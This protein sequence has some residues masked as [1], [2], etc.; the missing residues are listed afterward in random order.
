MRYFL[1]R[2]F[3]LDFF[4]AADFFAGLRVGFRATGFALALAFCFV[5]GPGIGFAFAL[6]LGF[7]FGCAAGAVSIPRN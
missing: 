2:A 6:A 3:G 5:L 7:A 1:A 4:F